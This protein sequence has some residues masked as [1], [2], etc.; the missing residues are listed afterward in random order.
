MIVALSVQGVV[1][2]CKCR[3]NVRGFAGGLAQPAE[4]VLIE[5]RLAGWDDYD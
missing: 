5:G 1:F 3:T 4:W 2:W